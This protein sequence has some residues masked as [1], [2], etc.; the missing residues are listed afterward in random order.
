MSRFSDS[1]L[2][3]LKSPKIP[4]IVE[5]GA[6]DGADTLRFLKLWPNSKIYSFEPIPTLCDQL[7]KKF[8]AYNNVH[9]I[10]K[11]LAP[12][13]AKDVLIHTFDFGDKHNGSSSLLKPTRHAEFF[14]EID[15]EN[16]LFVDTVNLDFF[17][18]ENDIHEIFLL[19]LDLQ[20]MELEVL[21]SS[22]D[23]L[24][25]VSYLH[26]EISDTPLY[27]DGTTIGELDRF[28]EKA[29]FKRIATRKLFNSGN[30]IYENLNL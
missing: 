19:W 10:Q 7:K 26:L 18:E 23:L 22:L 9:I 25:K 12:T 8:S 30:A 24:S 28:L 16:T 5:A 2:L 3:K 29:G 1:Y 11:A 21:N 13:T 14:P 20:G 17:C 15:L 4:V 6:F 27:L